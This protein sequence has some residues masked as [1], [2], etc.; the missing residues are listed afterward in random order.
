MLLTLR[1]DLRRSKRDMAALRDE[2][3]R[4]KDDKFKHDDGITSYVCDEVAIRNR[5][6]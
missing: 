5:N 3:V 6:W 1:D 4:V 2:L